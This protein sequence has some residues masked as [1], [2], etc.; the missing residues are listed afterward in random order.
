MTDN[1]T[2]HW[3]RPAATSGQ[4]GAVTVNV[5]A[6]IH[7]SVSGAYGVIAQSVSGGG[8]L[9][10]SGTNMELLNGANV[11]TNGSALVSGKAVCEC[12]H[13]RLGRGQRGVAAPA[14]RPG[15]W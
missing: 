2:L 10:M 8:G 13:G 14:S 12:A 7:T 4:G 5:S 1:S 15:Q 6:P 11:Q 3:N 9:L